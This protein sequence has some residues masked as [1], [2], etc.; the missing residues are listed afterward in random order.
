MKPEMLKDC[1]RCESIFYDG[2]SDSFWAFF[3]VIENGNESDIA[4]KMPVNE[5]DFIVGHNYRIEW[6]KV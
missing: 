4:F 5:D 1:L 2:D 3:R 6:R